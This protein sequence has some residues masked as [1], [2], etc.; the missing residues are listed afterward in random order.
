MVTEPDGLGAFAALLK[1]QAAVVRRLELRLEEHRLV[2]IAQ[3]DVLLE[4]NSAPDRRLRM[5][6]LSERVVLSRSRV[7]RVVDEM[8]RAGLVRKEPDPD[9]RRGAYAVI[10]DDGRVALRAAA[11]VYLAGIEEEFLR[12][13]SPAE[14]RSI[15]KSL[16]KVLA[17]GAGTTDGAGAS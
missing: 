3:Y 5:Q 11:P 8:V 10:T 1:V 7:S 4:L 2:P 12:H 9:D 13:L 15:E 6:Q 17:A 14:R 16:R